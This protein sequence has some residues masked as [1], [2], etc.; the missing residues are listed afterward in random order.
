MNISAISQIYKTNSIFNVNK[1]TNVSFSHNPLSSDTFVPTRNPFR[2]LLYEGDSFKVEGYNKLT[3]A[4]K[5]K[6]DWD[7]DIE[8]KEDADMNFEVGK[9]FK[10]SLDEKY[11]ENNYIFECIGTSPAPIGRFLDFSG[12]EVHYLPI[13]GLKSYPTQMNLKFYAKEK[14]VEEYGKFLSSQGIDKDITKNTD[15]KILF[16]DFTETGSS[17]VAFKNILS[18]TY[19]VPVDDE[20]IEFR[21][22]NKDLEKCLDEE[23]R[24]ILKDKSIKSKEIEKTKL[25]LTI[26]GYIS[27]FLFSCNAEN[28]GDVPHLMYDELASIFDKTKKSVYDNKKKERSFNF[29]TMYKLEQAGMLK[30]NPA[31]KV[32]L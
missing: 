7:M 31:N 22:L 1:N 5:D 24:K 8:I 20:Q 9:I 6:I 12:I 26:N 15:K 4:E 13:S 23:Y 14:G 10:K 18:K 19:G 16:Y 32:S 30:E 29:R 25:N 21:S 17:L 27:Y 28:Y 11:G 3:K 2:I